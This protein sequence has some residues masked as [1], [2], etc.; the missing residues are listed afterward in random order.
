MPRYDYVLFDADNTLLDFDRAEEEALRTTLTHYGFADLET[1]QTRYLA[2]NRA[3]WSRFDRGEVSRERLVVER[4]AALQREL[5]G[6][7]DPAEVNRFYLAC[8]GEGGYLLPGAAE[9]CR[10]L[11]SSCTLAIVTNGVAVAQ[12]GRFARSGLG[13]TVSYLFISEELGY[14]KPQREFFDAALQ[15]LAVPDRSRVVVVGDSLAADILGAVNAGL[16]SIWYNPAGAS[17]RVDVVPT[18]EAQNYQ[19]VLEYILA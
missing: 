13:E 6:E 4:F 10:A 1:A 3:L 16:D 18:W 17:G 14:Q 5:G 7:N 8:L 12:R 11:A 9:L 2:I 19:E 15:A